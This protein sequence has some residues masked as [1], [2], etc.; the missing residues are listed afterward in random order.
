MRILIAEDDRVSRILL[1]R[2][3]SRW[4][5]EPVVCTDGKEALAML[6]LPDAPDLALLD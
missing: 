6:Q 2:T 1:E 4:G 3:L 5:F